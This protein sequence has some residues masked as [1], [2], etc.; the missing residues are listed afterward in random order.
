[1]LKLVSLTHPILQILSNNADGGTSDF[2]IS[3]QSLISENCHNSRTTHDIDMKLG[4]VT[5]LEKRNKI[6]PNK[7]G[8]L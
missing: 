3:G 4:P 1:M 8:K 5:K 6:I 7:F 2:G